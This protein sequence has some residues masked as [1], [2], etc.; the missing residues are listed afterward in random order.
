MPIQQKYF[1]WRDVL[2]LQGRPWIPLRHDADV[3]IAVPA[4]D[5]V[6][7]REY[8]GIA[9]AAIH[10]THKAAAE[11]VTWGDLG[12][13]AH[14]G[15]MEPW[16]YRAS[17]LFYHGPNYPIGINLVI[18]QYL[19]DEH[20]HIWHLHPDLTLAL[21]LL[22]EGDCW[23]R[24]EEGWAEV[25]RLK[26]DAEG[27]PTLLEIRAEYLGDYLSARGMALYCSSYRQRSATTVDK[28]VY[29]WPDGAFA[30]VSGRDERDGQTGPGR[31]PTPSDQYRTMGAL[32]RTEWVQPSGLSTRIRGDKD[33]HTTSFVLENDGT[34]AR[35]DELAG[36]S[37]WL[38]FDPTIVSTLMRHRGASLHWYSAETG[39]L[40]AST[41]VHFGVNRVGLITVFAKDIGALD[42]WEQRLWS[43]HNV[44]PEGGVAEELFAAQMEV[45]PASTMAPESQ[46][47]AALAEIDAAFATKFGASLLRDDE[48]VPRLLRRAHRFQAA[49][50]EG[51]L[52]LS[53]EVTRLFM[54]RVD[55]DAVL[56][57][58][59]L[60]KPKDGRK[61]GSNKAIEKL[62]GSLMPEADAR[63]MM[64]P[65]FGIYDLRLADAH[66]GSSNVASGKTRA[67][68]DDSAPAAMQGRQLLDTFVATLRQ[69]TAA[70][71]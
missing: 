36:A 63:T 1:E 42:P 12:V 52:E 35:G 6:E 25:V 55:V 8:T 60:P 46:L 53:K 40:G 59:N 45:T 39:G 30:E 22:R 5:I 69:I 58:L 48:A 41:S 44:T 47:A 27:R 13:G 16:G 71:A 31:W 56:A 29:S 61:P 57:P 38:Y 62:L 64:A 51:L 18:D 20:L 23:F 33:P 24:P 54:E 11:K 28:P 26:R 15:G 66:L 43:A 65:L 32:W 70:I 19:E 3:P 10:D 68:V 9:T 21:R 2:P 49:E 14:R 7:L 17:D 50:A 37:T 34:R 4:P 67:G